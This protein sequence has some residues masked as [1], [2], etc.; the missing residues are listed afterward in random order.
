[1]AVG[2]ALGEVGDAAVQAAQADPEENEEGL[3]VVGADEMG[4]EHVA[5]P[6]DAE[7][8]AA[9]QGGGGVGAHGGVVPER[10][11]AG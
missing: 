4:D 7:G 3:G 9:G 5:Q 6:G 2:E 11:G 8:E 10:G 1:M